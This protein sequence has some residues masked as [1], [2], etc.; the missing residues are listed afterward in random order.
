MGGAKE[1]GQQGERFKEAAMEQ[2]P[3]VEKK[4]K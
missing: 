1:L 2:I 3:K 4:T